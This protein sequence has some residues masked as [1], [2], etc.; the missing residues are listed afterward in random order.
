MT[1][2][3]SQ[4]RR[5]RTGE[6][7]QRVA[8]ARAPLQVRRGGRTT[9]SM[10]CDTKVRKIVTR[11]TFDNY[12]QCLLPQSFVPACPMPCP[13]LC[14]RSICACLPYLLCLN[15]FEFSIFAYSPRTVYFCLLIRGWK[16]SEIMCQC[17][18]FCGV[19]S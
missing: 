7:T 19:N 6:D 10:Y 4:D 15:R 2:Q 16:C 14:E 5:T 18:R 13:C 1:D 3:S 8:Y 17:F 11:S 12:I 9:T